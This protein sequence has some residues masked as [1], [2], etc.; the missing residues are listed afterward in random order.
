MPENE[1]EYDNCW[2]HSHYEERCPNCDTILSSRQCHMT[3]STW[4]CWG[5]GATLDSRVVTPNLVHNETCGKV[6]L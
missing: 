1:I 5:C 3:Y 4:K 6:V 2:N